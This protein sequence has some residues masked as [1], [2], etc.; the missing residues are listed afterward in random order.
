MLFGGGV[1]NRTSRSLQP[2]E[3]IKPRIRICKVSNFTLVSPVVGR[4]IE[5]SLCSWQISRP[6]FPKCRARDDENLNARKLLRANDLYNSCQVRV[7]ASFKNTNPIHLLRAALQSGRAA[8]AGPV[9]T[10]SLCSR[11]C[12]RYDACETGASSRQLGAS[13][14]SPYL[15]KF[16]NSTP[17][18]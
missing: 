3:P 7:A 14:I 2:H 15:A 1:V 10:Q 11:G 12:I 17:N 18:T 4:R 16:I 9:I 5:D 8:I 6:F 13:R